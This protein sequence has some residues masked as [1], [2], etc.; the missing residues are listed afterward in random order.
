MLV[1]LVGF[2]ELNRG[3]F[4]RD[5]GFRNTVFLRGYSGRERDP[6]TQVDS[7]RPSPRIT[8]RWGR[9]ERAL[10]ARIGEGRYDCPDE[11]NCT[12]LRDMAEAMR[13]IMLHDELPES[14]RYR[15]A[16]D[17]MHVLRSA[18]LVARNRRIAD[19]FV[20]A[21]GDTPV[22]VWHKPGFALRTVSD[23][24]FIHR[25]DT[26]ERWIVAMTARPTREALQ[27]AA[28]HIAS[29]LLSGAL[30]DEVASR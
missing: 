7:A 11:G 16:D 22:T 19:A 12:T 25:T 2:D 18:M 24:L 15:I 29:L 14:E 13:R 28:T 1:E 21:F 27:D 9:R 5:N 3:F 6:V 20:E 26:N 23:T 8:L 30:C 4:V 17:A 10:P